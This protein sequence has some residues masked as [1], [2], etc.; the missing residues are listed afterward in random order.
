MDGG[1]EGHGPNGG[2]AHCGENGTE[3]EYKQRRQ[4]CPMQAAGLEEEQRNAYDG[5]K[6]KDG[7]DEVYTNGKHTVHETFPQYQDSFYSYTV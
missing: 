4:G 1:I 2:E 7:R 5:Q 6:N 3:I